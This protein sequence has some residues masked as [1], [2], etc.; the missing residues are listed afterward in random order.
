MTLYYK[1]IN[2]KT[3]QKTTRLQRFVYNLSKK[4]KL[5]AMMAHRT[6]YLR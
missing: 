4:L 5:M 2:I 3:T 6:P 1:N